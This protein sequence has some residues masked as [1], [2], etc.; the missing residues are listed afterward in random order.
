MVTTEVPTRAPHARVTL[1]LAGAAT[2]L[3]LM[4]YSAPLVTL[5][6]IAQALDADLTAQVWIIG[7]INLGL[8]ALLL[9]A[10]ALADAR[11]RKRVFVAGAVVLALAAAAD[12]VATG[13]LVFVLGRIVQGAASAALLAA[14]LGAVGH[15]FPAG[16]ERLRAT[17]VWGAMLGGGTMLGP[18]AAAVLG[19]WRLWYVV[20]A[21]AAALLAAAAAWRLR[22]S[23][24]TR[25]REPD[26]PGALTLGAGFAALVAAITWGRAD[27][28]SPEVVVA[29][30]A[31]VLLLA[32]FAVIESR[33]REPMLDL[34][35]F[36]NPDFTVSVIGA[37]FL[38]VAVIGVISYLPTVL[39]VA[40]GMSFLGAA[41][42]FGAWSATSFVIA[43]QVRRL[44]DR[45][46]GRHLV[47]AGLVLC[48]AGEAAMLGI[49]PDTPWWRLVPG[50][51]VCGVGTG[52]LNAVLAS[53]AV[54]SVP[55][56]RAGMGSGAGNTARYLGAS[57]GV[58]V[59]VAVATA[60]SAPS[61]AAAMTEGADLALLASLLIACCGAALA[62]L[63]HRLAAR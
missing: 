50:L 62:L 63:P 16:P 13:P 1:V 4:N 58:A 7:G 59:M 25:R 45:V 44:G 29:A 24:A 10:G 54:A 47:A 39:H 2:L 37:L 42:L 12:A 49:H 9:V 26:L 38:G 43:L 55:A 36:R 21:G 52:M 20:T 53:L 5:P 8:A 18:V 30:G 56:D 41:L 40:T 48:A 11:G 27:W 14:G 35:L 28:T 61:V 46:A 31:A 6:A 32:G 22:E 15:A 33:R 17:G 51:V 57:I 3:A 23:R 60:P 19:G 34:G